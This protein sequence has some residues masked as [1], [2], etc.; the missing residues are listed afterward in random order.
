VCY[1]DVEQDGEHFTILHDYT[2]GCASAV[3]TYQLS[4]LERGPSAT[5]RSGQTLIIRDVEA[6]LLPGE[7]ADMFNAI[8]IRAMI[9]CPLVKDG[10]L[11]AMMAVHQ[12]T[13]RE[14]KPGRDRPRSGRRGTLLG[15]D[16]ARTAEENIRQ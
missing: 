4:L 1:A 9:S 7:G 10:G 12:T 2:D 16:R 13:P 8:G 15:D 5:L 3:G 11:R 14:W 6:E